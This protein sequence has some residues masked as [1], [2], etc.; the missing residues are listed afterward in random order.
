MSITLEAIDILITGC[1]S[2]LRSLVQMSHVVDIVDGATEP[3]AIVSFCIKS[4]S[5]LINDGCHIYQFTYVRLH[6]EKVRVGAYVIGLS[7]CFIILF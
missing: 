2:C 5:A 1:Y 6:Q 4:S 7:V 3:D